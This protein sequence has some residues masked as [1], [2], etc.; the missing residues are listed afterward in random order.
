[1]VPKLSTSALFVSALSTV[2]LAEWS[3]PDHGNFPSHGSSA[4]GTLDHAPLAPW[5]DGPTPQGYGAPWGGRDVKNTNPYDQST[6]PNTGMTRHYSWT[7]TNTTLAPDGVSIPML[8]VNGQFPGPLIEANWGDWIEVTVTNGLETEGTALHWH[9]FLQTGTPWYD[10]VPGVSQCPIAPGKTFTY[11]FRAELYGTSW[12]HGHYSA[13]YINGLAGPIVVHGP[14]SDSYDIDLG[15]VMFSDWFHDYYINLVEQVFVASP[16]GPVFPPMA[17]NMLIQGKGP[18]N[19]SN[20]ALKCSPNA[21]AAAFKFQSGK[22]HLL[23]LI[24][25]SAEAIIFFS[26]DGYNMTV[27]S[28]DFVPVNPYVTDLITL[29][30]GQ[31]TEVIVEGTGKPTDAVWMRI[32]EGPSGLGPAGGTGCSLNDGKSFETTAGIYYEKANP[33]V[34]PTTK[35]AIDPSRYLFP[36]NCNNQPLNVT[37]PEYVMP[38]KEPSATLYFL[39]TGGLNST[40]KFVWWMNNVTYLANFNDPTLFEAKLGNLNFPIERAV[41]NMGT[42]TSVRIVMTSVG[43]PASHPMHIHGHNMQVLSEGLGSWDGKSIVNPSNPQR[44]DTQLIQPNGYLVVQIDLNNP[45]VWPFHCHV[46]WHTSEGMN[47]NFLEQNPLV[48]NEMQLPYIM[49]QTCRDWSAW[50]GNHIVD[51]IDSG[52]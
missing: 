23:R 41:Y 29:A 35:T 15:P 51:Q 17:N 52:L 4:W 45:G 12:W 38:L 14:K 21:P 34:P 2:A 49:A 36:L 47:I 24:N 44:R 16:V 43:F 50:T 19:C 5:V 6:V 11:R 39:M 37:T 42:N 25:H 27:I 33:S 7:V 48:E 26:I 10:G 18:Y 3:G 31:R 30:V 9:G 13:Q 8:V 46:A 20:T 32:T 22:K 40:G 1:M 28:N